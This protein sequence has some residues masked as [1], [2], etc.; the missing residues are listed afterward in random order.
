MN[1]RVSR[2][3]V[4]KARKS[5]DSR[6]SRPK[7][8]SIGR[9]MLAPFFG[10]GAACPMLSG[11][12]ITAGLCSAILVGAGHALGMRGQKHAQQTAHV[13]EPTGCYAGVL[14]WL[15]AVA[16]HDADQL[17]RPRQADW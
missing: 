13:V 15:Q 2:R 12:S 17:G 9:E 1:A 16:D 8:S 3:P 5:V 4:T 14:R 6:Q 7:T 10:T 11:S